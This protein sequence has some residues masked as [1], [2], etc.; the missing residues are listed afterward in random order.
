MHHRATLGAGTQAHV[1]GECSM[2]WNEPLSSTCSCKASQSSEHSRQR[3]RETEHQESTKEG[4]R[5][6]M[7][8]L[9]CSLHCRK[10]NKPNGDEDN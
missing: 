6:M 7:L 5:K 2:H 1:G 10:Q 8:N 9:A 4:E 3:S